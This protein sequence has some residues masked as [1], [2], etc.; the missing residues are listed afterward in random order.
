MV[1]PTFPTPSSPARPDRVVTSSLS[2]CLKTNCAPWTP[3]SCWSPGRLELLQS[4]DTPENKAFVEAFKA[5]CEKN[6]LPG[7]KDHCQPLTPSKPPTTAF[8]C[9]PQPL[10]AGSFDVDKVRSRLW[11]QF[12]A[13]GG[14]KRCTPPTSTPSS[15]FISVKSALTVSS[16]SFGNQTAW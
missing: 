10:K 1:T 9:G 13:P 15:L 6:N 11:T 7:G 8:T 2:P 5:Y 14:K 3:A 4:I 16:T 12:D